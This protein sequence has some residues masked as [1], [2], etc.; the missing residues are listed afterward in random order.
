MSVPVG[1]RAKSK[2]EVLIRTR[3]LAKYTIEITKNGNV[4][5]PEYQTAL[6]D[7]LIRLS[8]DIFIRCWTA[9]NIRVETQEQY[10]ERRKLQYE[11]ILNCN[12]LLALIDLAKS[13]YHLKNKRVKFW[14]EKTI[15]SRTLI[16]EWRNSDAKRYQIS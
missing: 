16:R 8:K 12:N 4:F 15:L 10:E 13:V 9:N 5:L 6:T 3:E 7:D 2:F 1:K 14:A 11:A